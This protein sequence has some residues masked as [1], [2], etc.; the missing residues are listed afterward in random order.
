M[1]AELAPLI[2][3]Q[4]PVIPL[5]DV[6]TYPDRQTLSELVASHSPTL[7]F[8]D[9]ASHRETAFGIIA[10]LLHLSP[11]IQ[12]VVLMNAN[13]PDL[14]L[15][16]LRQGAAEFL[17]RPFTAD[18]LHP[19]LERLAQLG[20]GAASSGKGG[21][22]VYCVMP[23]KGACGASTIACSLA[24]QWKKQGAKRI[25]LADM[26]PMT[27]TLS[28]LLKLKSN[29]S[30]VDALSRGEMLDSDL[31]KGM[32]NAAQGIDVLLS[33]ESPLDGLHDLADPGPVVDFCRQA[34]DCVTI[35]AGGAFGNWPLALANLCDD[36]LLVTTNEL[37]ALRATQRALLHFDR[38]RIDR[39]KIRLIV[40][41]YSPSV[42]LSQEA[43]ETALHSD[44]YHLIPSDYESVQR[45]LVEGRPIPP[46]SPFGRNIAALA[47]RLG[48]FKKESAPKKKSSW[49][50]M[51]SS[52]VSR[53]TI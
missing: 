21:A 12:I 8:L 7:C 27:G 29:Y 10:S 30:F 1:L 4:L 46:S 18:Q 3:Q 2:R 53:A 17:L 36:L 23:V 11:G 45:A 9:V 52:L 6:T 28:F 51:F 13:E 32:T 50:S 35:D 20:G 14:I 48:G 33:P 31:W 5:V 26:D 44:V 22:R 39:A 42:G 15:G 16:C 47:D 19:V 24:F 40:N 49:T 25:L 37:P 34:Y 38:N 43:I 41:R